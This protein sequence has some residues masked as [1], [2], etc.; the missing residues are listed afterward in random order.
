MVRPVRGAILGATILF[1]LAGCAGQP[2]P[3]PSGPPSITG[4]ITSIDQAGEQ[5]GSIRVEAEPADSAGSPK[6][7]A[8]ITPGTRVVT[9]SGRGSEFR[10]LEVGQWVRVWFSG[11][12][13]ESYPVQ[14]TAATVV[15]DSTSR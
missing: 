15:I 1:L 4:Q 10:A 13:M 9:A 8:R 11:P 14:A 3:G 5:I 6:A 12:V 7:M 2:S